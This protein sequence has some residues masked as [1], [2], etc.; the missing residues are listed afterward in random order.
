MRL[1]PDEVLWRLRPGAGAPAAE[2][3]HRSLGL[4]P[5]LDLGE[6]HA[7]HQLPHGTVARVKIVQECHR[8]TCPSFMCI[9]QSSLDI[10]TCEVV[11]VHVSVHVPVGGAEVNTSSQ[12]VGAVI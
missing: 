4:H 11:P 2:V 5:A 10:L 6:T 12:V 7:G 8:L 3:G 1:Q 9:P